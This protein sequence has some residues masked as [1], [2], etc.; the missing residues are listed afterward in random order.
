MFSLQNVSKSFGDLQVVKPTTI[1][2]HEGQSTVLIGPSGCGKSTLL[3]LL[4]GLIVP[5]SGT[6]EF[7]GERLTPSNILSMRQRMGYVIQ[8]GGLFPHLTA[9]EN[10]GLLAKHLCWDKSKID[11]RV[12]ELA[13]LTRLPHAALGRYPLQMSGGQRQRV[14][15]MR[16]LMLDPAVVLLDEPMGALD[17]LVRFDLQEDLRNIFRTLRKTSIMVTHDM[18]EAGFFGDRVLLLSEGSIVQEGHLQD[19][20]DRP[21]N[22]YVTRFINAQRIP[23]A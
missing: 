11:K 8:D 16:A 10:V 20:I 21:A 22:E 17:P 4:I 6:I 2:F 19:L 18:G 9:Q 5:D 7:A 14:G 1:V 3:R 15:I 23:Q 13:D 12:R